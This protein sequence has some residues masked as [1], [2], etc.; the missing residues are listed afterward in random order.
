MCDTGWTLLKKDVT[1]R[2]DGGQVRLPD[3]PSLRDCAQACYFYGQDRVG[4][5]STPCTHFLYHQTNKRCYKEANFVT[6]TC[7]PQSNA[8]KTGEK[9]DFFKLSATSLVKR[10]LRLGP[11]WKSK[12]YTYKIGY[13]CRLRKCSKP[14]DVGVAVNVDKID[15]ANFQNQLG[16]AAKLSDTLDIGSGDK[17]SNFGVMTWGT[18]PEVKF[19]FGKG[20]DPRNGLTDEI[21]NK[22]VR[23]AIGAIKFV[24]DT[25]SYVGMAVGWLNK[26]FTEG[27]RRGRLSFSPMGVNSIP[28]AC[29]PARTYAPWGC[30]ASCV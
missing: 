11:S 10:T 18:S 22:A 29:P 9:Y 23:K 8:F 13:E 25:L 3:Q 1:C 15:A 6:D 4:Q 24:P 12:E 20:G 7:G 5:K 21:S 27:A 30:D 17:Q 14:V 28:P 26:W 16:F 2:A 19:G